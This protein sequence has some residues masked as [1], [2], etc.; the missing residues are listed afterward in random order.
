[1]IALSHKES[2][3]DQNSLF[4]NSFKFSL[5]HSLFSKNLKIHAILSKKNRKCFIFFNYFINTIK[6]SV[7]WRD[8]CCP[9][10]M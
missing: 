9:M 3:E 5:D 7:F 2:T 6:H 10:V 8:A 4:K 1:M